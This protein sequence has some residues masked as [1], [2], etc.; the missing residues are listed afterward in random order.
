MKQALVDLDTDDTGRVPLDVFHAQPSHPKYS[1]SESAEYLRKISSLDESRSGTPKVMIANYLA[2]P[3]NCIAWSQ[4]FSVCCLN[5]CES[6]VN[7]LEARVQTSDVPVQQ[8]LGTVAELPSSTVNAPRELSPRLQE[9]AK[10][11]GAVHG[12][13][14]P[15]QSGD[16]RR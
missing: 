2:S 4:Y 3:S 5:E 8:L 11:V 16:F 15:L 12:G 1:F 6:L 10:S 7:E 9:I 14:V 13:V